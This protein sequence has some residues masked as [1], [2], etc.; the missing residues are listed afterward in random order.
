MPLVRILLPAPRRSP[1]KWNL[2]WSKIVRCIDRDVLRR[3]NP[4]CHPCQDPICDGVPNKRI[5]HEWVTGSCLL[6]EIEVIL[7]EREGLFIGGI[8]LESFNLGNEALVKEELPNVR[9]VVL[10]GGSYLGI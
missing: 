3:I 8:R 2:C 1:S 9:G 7:I 6:I 4:D 10:E 5:A